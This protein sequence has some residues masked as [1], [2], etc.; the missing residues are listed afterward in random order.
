LFEHGFGTFPIFDQNAKDTELF[1][2]GKSHRFDIDPIFGKCSAGFPHIARFVLQKE[3]K[4]FQFHGF[5]N[6]IIND[7]VSLSVFAYE[8]KRGT[9][10]ASFEFPYNVGTEADRLRAKGKKTCVIVAAV[11]NR[12]IHKLF[13]LMREPTSTGEAD[14]H[15]LRHKQESTLTGC[16]PADPIS[17]YG[18][19]MV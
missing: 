15:F 7:T 19:E 6:K 11:A 17:I 2:I 8:C 4:L 3:R 13:R 18:T 14:V 10:C 1:R 16:T 12:W 9:R 5:S